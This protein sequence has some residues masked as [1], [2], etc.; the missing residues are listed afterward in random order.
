MLEASAPVKGGPKKLMSGH[1]FFRA[2]LPVDDWT[3][4]LARRIFRPSVRPVNNMLFSWVEPWRGSRSPR[5]PGFVKNE[6]NY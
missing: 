2:D 5:D 6:K 1:S 4:L 3:I